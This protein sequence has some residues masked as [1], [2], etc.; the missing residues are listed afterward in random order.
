MPAATASPTASIASTV[1]SS[2]PP[3]TSTGTKG[4]PPKP[5]RPADY[6]RSRDVQI[7]N[8]GAGSVADKATRQIC[9]SITGGTN[10]WPVSY[11]AK[12][13]YLY[14]PAYEGCGKVTIDASAHVKGKF[15]GGAPGVGGTLTSSIT[16]LDAVSG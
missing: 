15:N 8:E 5:A 12:T 3:S 14:I 11:S 4:I 9:P 1:S 6:D 7:Y 13:G 2:R 10:F 16:L